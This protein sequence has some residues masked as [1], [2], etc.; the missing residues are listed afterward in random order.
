[1]AARVSARRE[2]GKLGPA[3]GPW[4]RERQL[5]K[6]QGVP[7][8]A[9][10]VAI[11]D[12]RGEPIAWG[13]WSE[14]SQIRVRV[15]C[16]GEAPPEPDWLERRI[17]AAHDARRGFASPETTGLR[18]V[19]SEG[20]GLPGLVVDQYTNDR[21]VQLSTAPMV[22]LR[23]RIL[24]ALRAQGDGPIH[25]VVPES[26]ARREDV[27]AEHTLEG[28]PSSLQFLEHG[29][30]F[31]VPP[32]PTQKTGAYFDQRANRRWVASLPQTR[33]GRLLDLGCHA[34]GF[35]LHARARGSEVVAVDRSREVLEIAARN[36]AA[37]GLD[38]IRWVA[39]D[40]FGPLAEE[41][42][43]G[44]FDVIVAD[45]PKVAARKADVDAAR[46]AIGR[47]V[48]RLGSRLRPN[49]LFVVCSCSHHF[50]RAQLDAAV[51]R[52]G[53]RFA[54]IG[55]RGADFDHPIAPGHVEGEY[56]RVGVYQR[57]DALEAR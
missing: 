20:D 52:S 48:A 17:A 18:M 38:G 51:M 21:V 6:V 8:P 15:L 34:G 32:P 9:E 13:L 2:A 41:E 36:A 56:L 39:A 30:R 28:E 57:R 33:G 45:P 19:N 40:M 29:L 27:E 3:G 37:N 16:W 23:P 54:R 53:L 55:W 14:A 50:G 10:P 7:T 46:V 42:L 12:K 43:A 31:S 4:V 1:M 47:L 11:V 22:A 49:G 26:A 25:V 5:G 44:P 35:A 24:A